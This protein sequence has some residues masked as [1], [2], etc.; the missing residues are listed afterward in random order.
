MD[1]LRPV[2][3][4]LTFEDRICPGCG[5]TQTYGY[6]SP[7]RNIRLHPDNTAVFILGEWIKLTNSYWPG[8]FYCHVDT[9][10]PHTNNEMER[11]IKE[12]KTLER[13]ISRTPNPAIRP[14]ARLPWLSQRQRDSSTRHS[15]SLCGRYETSRTLIQ[16]RCED[17]KALGVWHDCDESQGYVHAPKPR[18]RESS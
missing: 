9:R 3:L 4:H 18:R 7:G 14:S 1:K 5:E 15:H 10:I 17:R 12:L 13:H 11:F 2:R 8:P 6:C 16:E